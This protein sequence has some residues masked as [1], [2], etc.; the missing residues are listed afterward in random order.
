MAASKKKQSKQ[1]ASK[2]TVKDSVARVEA[3]PKKEAAK[4]KP[5]AMKPAVRVTKKAESEPLPVPVP[6]LQDAKSISED[7]IR[8]RAYLKWEAAGR[9]P[10]D[11]ACFWMETRYE[12]LLQTE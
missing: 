6:P 11:G 5:P 9:P 1:T 10:G 2:K 12:L 7:E 4:K 8:H 3:P